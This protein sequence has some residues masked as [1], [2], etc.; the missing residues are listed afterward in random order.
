MWQRPQTLYF[1]V[2]TALLC[3]MAFGNVAVIYAEGASEA[4]SYL[5]KLPYAVLIL[6]SAAANLLSVFCWGH[7]GLQMRLG[8]GSAVVLAG[9]QIWLA[10]DYFS[11]ADGIVFKFSAI[12]PLISLFFDIL[13]VRGVWADELLVRSSSRL[14][15]A[16]NRSKKQQ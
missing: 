1:A 7:R 5:A 14:R 16:R 2:A 13:A 11:A 4:V 15:S 6:I 8:V 9:L 3:V 10:V 12:F